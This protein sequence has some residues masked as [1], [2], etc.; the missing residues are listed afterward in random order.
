MKRIL[1]ILTLICSTVALGQTSMKYNSEYENF[2]RAED[3]FEKEQYAAA[4]K[5]FRVFIN[6]FSRVNDPLYVKARY[7][8]A[9]SALELYNNDAIVLLQ[10]FNKN[11]PE[12]I[13]KNDIY[14]RLGKY[15][16]YK[17]KY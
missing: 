1:I 6:G 3:L 17:K 11:Y 13:F 15:F 9:V 14:F 12:S 8:E 2:Y 10:D 16:Y 7:Y 4:R 5:E